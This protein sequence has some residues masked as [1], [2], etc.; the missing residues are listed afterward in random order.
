MNISRRFC[1]VIS[2]VFLSGA[3]A[4]AVFGQA[5]RS[6]R[7]KGKEF[8]TGG[9]LTLCHATGS[10]ENPY[11]TITVSDN[12]EAHRNHPADIIPAPAAGCP[13]PSGPGGDDPPSPVPEPVTMLLFGAGVAAAGYAARKFKRTQ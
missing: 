5:D 11:V 1:V 2:V 12:G 9:T 10:R 6:F 3:V 13:G 8:G 4:V 7:S